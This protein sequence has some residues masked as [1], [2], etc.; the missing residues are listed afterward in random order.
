[1][2]FDHLWYE[3]PERN[4]LHGPRSADCKDGHPAVGV[5][6]KKPFLPVLRRKPGL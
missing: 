3:Q 4:P 1:M 6:I 5:V 2:V